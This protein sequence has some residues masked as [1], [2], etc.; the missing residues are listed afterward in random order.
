MLIPHVHAVCK[1]LGVSYEIL[2][3]DGH[4]EDGTLETAQRLR[5]RAL[6][7]IG[8]SYGDAFRQGIGEARGAFIITIDADA[9][10]DPEVIYQLWA[11]RTR[12]DLVIASRYVPCGR[13]EMGYFRK[14][15]SRILS[16]VFGKTPGPSLS[17]SF[18]RISTLS[19]CRA[20]RCR[21]SGWARL[22][23]STRSPHPD[24]LRWSKSLRDP[25]H[26]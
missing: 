13:A 26:L 25:F 7:Q 11:S 22:R 18:E 10:H 8:K 6:T 1:A 15:L 3:V 24:A 23:R 14:I 19:R 16:L 5:C 17:R 20:S 21:P 9:S 12:A 2:V 4:S